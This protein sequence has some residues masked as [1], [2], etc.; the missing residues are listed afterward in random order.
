MRLKDL[1]CFTTNKKTHQVSLHLKAKVLKME[2]LT[3]EQLWKNG[4]IGWP[5]PIKPVSKLK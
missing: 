4:K 2:G 3:P 1:F 5:K